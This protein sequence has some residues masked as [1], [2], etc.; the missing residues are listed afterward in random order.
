MARSLVWVAMS[1]RHALWAA[2]WWLVACASIT[3]LAPRAP[4]PLASVATTAHRPSQSLTPLERAEQATREGVLESAARVAW[5]ARETDA[6]S[7]QLRALGAPA[8][9]AMDC[10]DE[11][12]ELVGDSSDP[13]LLRVAMRAHLTRD[14]WSEAAAVAAR[15]ELAGDEE[16]ASIVRVAGASR[17]ASLWQAS[18]AACAEATVLPNAPVPVIEVTVNGQRVLALLDTTTHATRI[19]RS[20]IQDDGVLASLEIGGVTIGNVPFFS[21][22]LAAQRAL[23]TVPIDVV[24]GRDVL[25]RWRVAFS[26]DGRR[27]RLGGSQLFDGS[28]RFARCAPLYVHGELPM[29]GA[30]QRWGTP[31]HSVFRFVTGLAFDSTSTTYLALGQGTL[32]RMQRPTG[33]DDG[34]HVSDLEVWNL[35]LHGETRVL[36]DLPSSYPSAVGGTIGWPAIAGLQLGWRWMSV[37]PLRPIVLPDGDFAVEEMRPCETRLRSGPRVWF[38]CWLDAPAGERPEPTE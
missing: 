7:P 28:D 24:L 6:D 10:A 38:T 36:V 3:Q 9:L 22:D 17:G 35:Q 29:Y 14:R 25:F 2:P 23:A 16:A 4:E 31:D 20:V 37:L 13:A 30:A 11:A 18:G 5:D 27:V 34:L 26:H 1:L 33:R 12:I 21:R 32:E 15:P 8:A 19:A